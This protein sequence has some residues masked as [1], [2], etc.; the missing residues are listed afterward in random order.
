MGSQSF[1]GARDGHLLFGLSITI[2]GL[3]AVIGL[4]P[5]TLVLVDPLL[6]GAA[7]L[8]GGSVKALRMQ[9]SPANVQ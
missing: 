2:L 3:L 5:V 9:H 7:G 1:Q 4:S 6:L 8:F